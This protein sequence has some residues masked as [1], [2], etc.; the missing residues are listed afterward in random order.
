MH[1]V[2]MGALQGNSLVDPTYF[3]P[4]SSQELSTKQL[5]FS[6]MK[7]TNHLW[8]LREGLIS[9]VGW[10]ESV[11]IFIFDKS[12]TKKHLLSDLLVKLL[13]TNY[14]FRTWLLNS[15]KKKKNPA[16]LHLFIY[17]QNEPILIMVTKLHDFVIFF[18]KQRSKR[19]WQPWPVSTGVLTNFSK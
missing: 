19:Q 9:I 7:L 4:F 16:C 6:K 15:K 11:A 17:L 14:S 13:F 8:D 12:Q 18:F 5:A 1:A 2:L 10:L 3:L